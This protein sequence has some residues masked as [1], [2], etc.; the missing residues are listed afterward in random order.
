[1]NGEFFNRRRY[2]FDS[3]A[4]DANGRALLN[5]RSIHGEIYKIRPEVKAD[6]HA[7]TPTYRDVSSSEVTLRPVH[8]SA[9]NNN[10]YAEEWKAR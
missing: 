8:F 7:L 3:N 5:E 9:A 2:S 4:I 1:M 10:D 6:V